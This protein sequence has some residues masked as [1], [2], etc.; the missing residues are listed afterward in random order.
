MTRDADHGPNPTHACAA[1]AR[2]AG[3]S[4]GVALAVLLIGAWPTLQLAGSGS[5]SAMLTG[6][7][8]ALAMALLGMLPPV[9]ALHRDPPQRAAAYLLGVTVRWLGTLAALGG[10]LVLSPPHA[11]VLVVWIALGHGALLVVDTLALRRVLGLGSTT[12]VT[13]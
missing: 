4:F 9:L 1:Y 6:A 8:I 12:K 3:M 10:V 11:K 13:A 7:A 2:L 5:A